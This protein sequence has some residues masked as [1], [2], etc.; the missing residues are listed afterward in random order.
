[1]KNTTKNIKKVILPVNIF[2]AIKLIK[3]EKQF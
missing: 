3:D 2:S 1:M